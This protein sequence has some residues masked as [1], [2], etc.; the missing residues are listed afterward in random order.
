MLSEQCFLEISEAFFWLCCV[1]GGAPSPGNRSIGG[2]NDFIRVY[3]R[4]V[5]DFDALGE[6]YLILFKNK[7]LLYYLSRKCD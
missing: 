6:N 5:D 1:D 4:Q 3:R 2:K 7:L